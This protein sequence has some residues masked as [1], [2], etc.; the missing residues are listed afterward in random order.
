MLQ[1]VKLKEEYKVIDNKVYAVIPETG[2]KRLVDACEVRVE[3]EKENFELNKRK[4]TLELEL[5]ELTKQII[6]N[7]KL[8]NQIAALGYCKI[9]KP[10]YKKI[11]GIVIYD[12]QTQKPI[13]ER[14][15]HQLDCPS[16]RI[17]KW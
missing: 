2:S 7:T 13:I 1:S 3:L 14:Y 12:N 11:D 8:D 5:N 4:E 16:R 17:C 9:D 6:D 10:I 15:T